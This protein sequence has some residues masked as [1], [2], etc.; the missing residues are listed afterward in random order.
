MLRNCGAAFLD[1][2]VPVYT[3][4]LPWLNAS[5]YNQA[6]EHS[7]IH[8]ATPRRDRVML[9]GKGDARQEAI[10]IRY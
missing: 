6:Y 7:L 8:F 10:K 4:A 5:R 2:P 3:D 9:V 1:S